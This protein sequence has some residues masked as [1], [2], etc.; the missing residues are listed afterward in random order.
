MSGDSLLSKPTMQ[1]HGH[2]WSQDSLAP[3]AP[4]LALRK[5][6]YISVW[7]A[8]MR[9]R[10]DS[11]QHQLHSEG[12]LPKGNISRRMGVSGAENHKPLLKSAYEAPRD[13]WG[14]CKRGELVSRIPEWFGG[15]GLHRH[16][17]SWCWME[18][19]LVMNM[20]ES[21]THVPYNLRYMFK[22]RLQ[23]TSLLETSQSVFVIDPCGDD[24][25]PSSLSSILVSL[26]A[27]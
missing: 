19:W 3:G 11:G 23:P 13:D 17:Q 1:T 26:P 16:L 7:V 22:Q 20:G 21:L 8:G 24:Q 18:G 27:C 9:G 10:A 14:A 5:E 6:R 4:W 15:H 12:Q 25:L 2:H